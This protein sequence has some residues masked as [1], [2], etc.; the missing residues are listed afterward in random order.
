MITNFKVQLVGRLAENTNPL[1][2]YYV[3]DPFGRTWSTVS[4]TPKEARG[5]IEFGEDTAT[6]KLYTPSKYG[7]R[8]PEYDFK[9]LI[10]DMLEKMNLQNTYEYEI[11]IGWSDY[12]AFKFMKRSSLLPYDLLLEINRFK[13]GDDFLG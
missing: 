7:E 10:L 1:N 8:P 12:E 3:R 6:F 9:S 5:N 13:N 11:V 2:I 4:N